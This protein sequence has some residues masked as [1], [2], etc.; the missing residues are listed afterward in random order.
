MAITNDFWIIMGCH[1]FW[2]IETKIYLLKDCLWRIPLC[3]L[4]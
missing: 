4:L 1:L 2:R 3:H